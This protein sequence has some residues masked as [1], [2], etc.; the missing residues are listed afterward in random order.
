VLESPRWGYVSGA[1][2]GDQPSLSCSERYC[3]VS[4]RL[5]GLLAPIR[6]QRACIMGCTNPKPSL[7]NI[8]P[9]PPRVPP[10]RPW[11]RIL[12]AGKMFDELTSL[13]VGNRPGLAPVAAGRNIERLFAVRH[14]GRPLVVLEDGT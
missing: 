5:A 13:P 1:V 10:H 3:F 7:G 12:L 11:A 14:L 2:G 4:Q 9:T 6:S 8:S